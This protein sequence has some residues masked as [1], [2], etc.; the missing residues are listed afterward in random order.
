MSFDVSLNER[1]SL[2]V[3][4]MTQ[5]MKP[6]LL[7]VRRVQEK[8]GGYRLE[9]DV[10]HFQVFS[11]SL[12]NSQPRMPVVANSV[13]PH[14]AGMLQRFDCKEATE[15][16]EHCSNTFRSLRKGY[17]GF[18]KQL[19]KPPVNPAEYRPESLL[20]LRLGK[21]PKKELGIPK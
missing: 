1:L 2:G 14:E 17:F 3:V 9:H 21:S 7:T 10:L 15:Q 8:D 18:P 19:F 6:S 4:Q 12:S 11:T 16:I 13:P 20:K 5:P